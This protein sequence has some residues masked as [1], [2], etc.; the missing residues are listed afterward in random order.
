M[1]KTSIPELTDL[2]IDSDYTEDVD[3]AKSKVTDLIE[4]IN[5]NM[6]ATIVQCSQIEPTSNASGG[7][8]FD[9]QASVKKMTGKNKLRKDSYS[10]LVLGNWMIKVWHDS[11]EFQSE[12]NSYIPYSFS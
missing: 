2:K 3:D 11:V 1:C 7:Q 5:L 10:A 9:L 6:R 12:D 8:S 4:R